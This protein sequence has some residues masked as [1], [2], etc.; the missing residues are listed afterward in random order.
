MQTLKPTEDED[1]TKAHTAGDNR[2]EQFNELWK[3]SDVRGLNSAPPAPTLRV[4]LDTAL[5]LVRNQMP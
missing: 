1:T 3:A 5:P 4:Q 2:H